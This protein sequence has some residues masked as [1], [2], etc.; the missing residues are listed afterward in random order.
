MYYIMSF[1][2]LPLLSLSCH[3][4]SSAKAHGTFDE[5]IGMIVAMMMVMTSR[6]RPPGCCRCGEIRGAD[7]NGKDLFV[8]DVWIGI[9]SDWIRLS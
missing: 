3:Q 2:G 7:S 4:M 6:H 5:A 8:S 1:F 9:G